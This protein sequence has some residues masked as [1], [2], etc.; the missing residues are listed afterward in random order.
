MKNHYYIIGVMSG[1]SLDGI[2]LAY[3]HFSYTNNQWH[4]KIETATTIPY[5]EKWSTTLPNLIHN[6]KEE[7]Q[8]IDKE[9]TQYLAQVITNFI[10]KNTVKKLDAVASHGH[11]ALHQPK[12]GITYQLGNLP[13]IATLI[14]A[15]VIC[16]FRTQDVALQGQG[17]PLVPIGDAL[18][19]AAY[20][21]CLNL[22]GFANISFQEN[23]N[24]IAF[25]ICPVNSILNTYAQKL[26]KPYDKEGD[27]AASGIVNKTLLN[28]LNQIAYYQKKPPKSL[29]VEWL[30]AYMYPILEAA[31]LSEKNILRTFVEHI[32]IQISKLISNPKKSILITGGGALNTF[33]IQR[34]KANTTAKIKLPNVTTIHYKEA[35]IFGLLGVLK[36]RNEVNCLASVTGAQKNHSSGKI[37]LPKK[38]RI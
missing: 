22:G 30:E 7:L 28:Q 38:T 25:D 6:T 33:L 12:K 18:L 35:L 17:A 11:T 15:K 4:Y 37:Y 34:I 5:P 20:D 1:T 36:M 29:G 21:Y 16:D 8:Q 3:L 10:N 13:E 24:R 19:F 9:Y 14:N 2:D 27:F 26:G 31:N 32:A 23:Q